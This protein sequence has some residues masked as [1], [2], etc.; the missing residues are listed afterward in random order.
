M[1]VIILLLLLLGDNH[2]S[3]GNFAFN[4]IF[5]GKAVLLQIGIPVFVGA[6]VGF[7]RAPS[8]RSWLLLFFLS[9]ALT[10]L[11]SSTVVILTLLSCLMALAGFVAGTR[12]KKGLSICLLYFPSLVYV[13]AFGLFLLLVS[14]PLLASSHPANTTWPS[15]FLGHFNYL[16]KTSDF[17]TS[18]IA[19]IL[20]TVLGLCLVKGKQRWFLLVWATASCVF[21]LNPISASFLIKHFTGQNIYW[22]LFYIFPF[23]L[24]AGICAAAGLSRLQNW[25]A[26]LRLAAA[27]GICMI[28]M[29]G[30]LPSSS[31]SIFRNGT[32]ISLPRSKIPRE[33]LADARDVIRVACP[34][35]M[36]A[37]PGISGIVPL[38]TSRHPQLVENGLLVQYKF[39]ELGDPSRADR[40]IMASRL[41]GGQPGEYPLDTV[42]NI[43]IEE[44]VSS[45]VIAR[46][47]ADVR[48]VRTL[49][50]S[51]GY[52]FNVANANYL[53]ACKKTDDTAL[54]HALERPY[55]DHDIN[56]KPN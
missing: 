47:V 50:L 43:L 14:P 38:L 10:G 3:Y 6:S 8:C 19:L 21:F 56:A 11:T 30:H 35:P 37:P 33:M 17:P 31:T 13:L 5:Q 54:G 53:V 1:V 51:A 7:F 41:V 36:L 23:P 40:R 24:M 25:P 46:R 15:T 48:Q 39:Y 22:R 44:N 9:T 32:E 55:P 42:K 29:A 28:L 18:I 49:L 20:S 2:R 45:I 4:R 26:N 27:G 52:E 34:G 16:F 12:G